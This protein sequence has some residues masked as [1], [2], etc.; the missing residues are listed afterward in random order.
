MK[1]FE[2]N[3]D[4]N[5]TQKAR[6]RWQILPNTKELTEILNSFKNW[7]GL[8]IT[9][10]SVALIVNPKK[11]QIK[12]IGR[13]L[14]PRLM[15][16]SS[17]K[18]FITWVQNFSTNVL[19]WQILQHVRTA[20][21]YWEFLPRIRQDQCVRIKQYK[22]FNERFEHMIILSD[23]EKAF[24]QTQGPLVSKQQQ[25]PFNKQEIEMYF[26]RWYRIHVKTPQLTWYFM[27]KKENFSSKIRIKTKILDL[28]ISIL[29]ST[30]SSGQNN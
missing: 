6:P 30:Q 11:L 26:K 5:S 28:A 27:V 7:R 19:F 3:G 20:H 17:P 15:K 21:H 1:Q 14:L 23:E 25:K 8:F 2:T 12:T 10:A 22:T 24:D 16:K 18:S 9:E 29:H 4:R 13:Y